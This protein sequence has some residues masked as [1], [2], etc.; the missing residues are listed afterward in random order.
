M[1]FSGIVEQVVV[2][3]DGVVSVYSNLFVGNADVASEIW[4]WYEAGLWFVWV[5]V[6]AVL[7]VLALRQYHRSVTR[8]LRSLR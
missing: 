1:I 6:V 3:T 5:A 8:E 7:V 4:P 2:S